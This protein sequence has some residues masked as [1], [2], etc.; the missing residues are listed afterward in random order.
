MRTVS[1]WMRIV[2]LPFWLVGTHMAWPH[3]T[4]LTIVET[5]LVTLLV[6]QAVERRFAAARTE[7]K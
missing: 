1:D 5:A 3:P 6:Y 7:A 2:L 4:W